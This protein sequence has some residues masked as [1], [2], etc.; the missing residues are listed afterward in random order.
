MIGFDKSEDPSK[1]TVDR[2]IARKDLIKAL[3]Q[4]RTH[5]S[6][7][8]KLTNALRDV[9]SADARG[10]LLDAELCLMQ[11]AWA[12]GQPN[13]GLPAEMDP[14]EGWIISA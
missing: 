9:L 12:S 5:L 6:L 11:A 4:G 14:L 8:L 3:E 7:R 1:Q 10:D 13:Y 2:L